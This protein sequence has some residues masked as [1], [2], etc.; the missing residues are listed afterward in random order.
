MANIVFDMA[1]QKVIKDAIK[2]VCL[3][4]T[5]LYYSLVLKHLL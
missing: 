2:H 3:V 1:T 4:S 5:V